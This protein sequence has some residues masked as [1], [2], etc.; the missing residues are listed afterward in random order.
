[1]DQSIVWMKPAVLIANRKWGRRDLNPDQPVWPAVSSS[2]T[3]PHELQHLEP[4][5]LARLYPSDI[6]PWFVLRPRK[7]SI[8]CVFYK[9]FASHKFRI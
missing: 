7:G 1:M 9:A 2:A 5:V 6:C 8:F 3:T 4:A